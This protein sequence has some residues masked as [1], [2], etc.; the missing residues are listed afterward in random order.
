MSPCCPLSAGPAECRS[1]HEEAQGPSRAGAV[2]ASALP[3]ALQLNLPFI[4]ALT[5]CFV[6]GD[7][8][9]ILTPWTAE[10]LY[11][12]SHNTLASFFPLLVSSSQNYNVSL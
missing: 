6:D 10:I 11:L 5:F 8:S 2:H 4:G 3:A 7:L 1:G 12:K 9:P